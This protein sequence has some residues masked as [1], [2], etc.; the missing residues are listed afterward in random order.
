MP[1]SRAPGPADDALPLTVG[2]VRPLPVAWDGVPVEW[3]AWENP[4]QAILCP[5]QEPTPCE[6]CGSRERP[7]QARGLT[8]V[9]VGAA[10]LIATRCTACRLDTVWDAR[11]DQW[12]T[13]DDT[14][15]GPEGS[16]PP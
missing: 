12:W 2:L 10:L 3:S 16:N 14:D 11:N 8:Q 15:Y 4:V 1:P 6:S 13:L 7:V 5:P 9:E